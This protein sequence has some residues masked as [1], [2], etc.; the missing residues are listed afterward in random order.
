MIRSDHRSAMDH[1]FA[2]LLKSAQWSRKAARVN[3]SESEMSS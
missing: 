2:G 1:G 3:R